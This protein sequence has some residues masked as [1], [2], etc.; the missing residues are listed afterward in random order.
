MHWQVIFNKIGI[1]T[2]FEHFVVG[3]NLERLNGIGALQTASST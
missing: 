3:G 1:K 2:T